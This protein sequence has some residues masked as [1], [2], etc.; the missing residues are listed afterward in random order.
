MSTS[1]SDQPVQVPPR[2]ALFGLVL[3]LDGVYAILIF[4]PGPRLGFSPDGGF[5]TA[6]P[7]LSLFIIGPLLGL[8]YA[9]HV[10]SVS[11]RLKSDS[12][13]K[14]R[15]PLPGRF[16]WIKMASVV[17]AG[18][19]VWVAVTVFGLFMMYVNRASPERLQLWMYFA[20]GTSI[21]FPAVG[22]VWLVR[23]ILVWAAP[24]ERTRTFRYVFAASLVPSI[25]L[26][27]RLIYI[28]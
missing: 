26:T 20:L 16:K 13:E 23:Q 14:G 8:V 11:E 18:A 17:L 22:I 24:R 12:Q 3:G 4:L 15:G 2:F 10:Y 5:I 21:V 27:A 7:S 19:I 1:I 9:R 28:F 6:L 25:I